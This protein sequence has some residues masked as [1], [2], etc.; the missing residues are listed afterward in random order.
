M[1]QISTAQKIIKPSLVEVTGDLLKIVI[2]G[3]TYEFQIPTIS[4]RLATASQS[5]REN[6]T[7]SASGYGIHWRELDEDLSI[8]GLLRMQV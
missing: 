5:Q 4:T 3:K 8:H 1:E 2:E 6:F 7:L